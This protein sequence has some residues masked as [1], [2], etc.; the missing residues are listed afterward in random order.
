[1]SKSIYLLTTTPTNHTHIFHPLP[2]ATP[3]HSTHSTIINHTFNLCKVKSMDDNCGEWVE[4][5]SVASGS[6]WNLWVCLLG[7]VVRRYIDF[8]ILLIPTPLVSVLF[9]SSI[10]TFCSFKMFFVLVPV[11]KFYVL[12]NFFTQYKHTYRQLWVSHNSHM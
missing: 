10:P 9:C 4:C 8:L 12:N 2:L 3:I 6:G 11:I 7:V 5:M 1:M